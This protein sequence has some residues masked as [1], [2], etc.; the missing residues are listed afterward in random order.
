MTVKDT[1]G[2]ISVK[3][4]YVN[5]PEEQAGNAFLA[6]RVDYHTVDGYTKSVVYSLL[7]KTNG[8]TVPFGTLREA[9]KTIELG[10]AEEFELGIAEEAPEDWDGKTVISFE[11]GNTGKW[12][13]ASFLL[14]G[15]K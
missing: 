4:S 11:I 13:E 2:R 9:D 3:P 12:S 10:L 7:G 15:T 1:C 14:M 8:R 6:V 5:I